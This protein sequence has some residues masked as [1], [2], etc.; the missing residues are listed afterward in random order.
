MIYA[1]TKFE[2]ASSNCLGEDTITRNVTDGRTTD[3]LW[4]D[5]NIPYFSNEKAGIITLF[6]VNGN[7]KVRFRVSNSLDPD[8]DHGPSV[9][10]WMELLAKVI[11]RQQKSFLERKEFISFVLQN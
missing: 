8:Q 5:F 9:L 4:Y 6:P 3:L 10:I 2:V 7:V 1:S 11:S